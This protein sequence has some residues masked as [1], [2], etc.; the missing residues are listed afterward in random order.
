MPTI[1]GSPKRTPPRNT[2]APAHMQVQSSSAET[3][4]SKSMSW[5][6]KHWADLVI[7]GV[8]A[9]MFLV[10]GLG[11]SQVKNWGG[12][13]GGEVELLRGEVKELRNRLWAM[14]ER[15]GKLEHPCSEKRR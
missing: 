7:I 11:A 6:R 3:K 5:T 10:L 12:G 14:E 9:M 2:P 13:K 1:N 15:F 8:F 4:L